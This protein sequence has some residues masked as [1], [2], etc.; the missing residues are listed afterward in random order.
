MKVDP[1]IN[2]FINLRLNDILENALHKT[3][4]RSDVIYI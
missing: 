3:L 4:S 1:I 2:N